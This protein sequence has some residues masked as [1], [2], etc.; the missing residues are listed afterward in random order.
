MAWE[1]RHRFLFADGANGSMT[2]DDG[3]SVRLLAAITTGLALVPVGIFLLGR[4]ELSVVL[5]LVNVLLIAGSLYY[6][7]GPAEIAGHAVEADRSA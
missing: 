4:G 3:L 7:F 6:L 2:S 5:S 1:R